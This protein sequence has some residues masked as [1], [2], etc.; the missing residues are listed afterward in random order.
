MLKDALLG[1]GTAVLATGLALAPE[2]PA[3]G[4]PL[5]AVGFVAVAYAVYAHYHPAALRPP[6]WSILLVLMGAIAYALYDRHQS[7]RQQ[8]EQRTP[9]PTALQVFKAWGT[10]RPD[11]CLAVLNGSF[12]VD[13]SSKYDVGFVCG[14]EDSSLDKFE[15]T[16]ITFSP[17]FTIHSGDIEITVNYSKEM[18]EKK[19]TWVNAVAARTPKAARIG[20]VSISTREWYEPVL[21][22]RH[23][24]RSDI[25]K[26]SDIRRYGGVLISQGLPKP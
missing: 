5:T 24:N 11:Q 25:H 3:W 15:D 19:Q 2:H 12:L 4:W 8:T 10:N 6:L 9:T 18:K 17:A 13:W 26:L 21:Y 7:G 20:I 16:R 14:F 1:V 23:L 22:P